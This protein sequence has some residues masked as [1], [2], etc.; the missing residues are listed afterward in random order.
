MPVIKAG[1][2]RKKEAG[3]E[4]PLGAYSAEL[5][6]DSGGL[7]QFG[8]LV[9][10]L[11]PGSQSSLPHWHRE[12][13]EMVLILSGEVILR[14]DGEETPLEPGDAVCW[15]KDTPVAHCLLNRS[16]APARYVIVGTRAPLDRVTYPEH[17]RVQHVDR[18]HDERRFTTLAGGPAEK[19]EP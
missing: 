2:A 15:P 18:L 1:T 10:E 13:D 8:A 6:S 3:P 17:D 16:D 14:E 4:D 11:A 12:E 5:L 7:T 9:E 19:P